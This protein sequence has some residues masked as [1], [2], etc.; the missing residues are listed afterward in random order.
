[1]ETGPVGEPPKIQS[2][3]APG[4][5]EEPSETGPRVDQEVLIRAIK[6]RRMQRSEVADTSDNAKS[7]QKPGPLGLPISPSLPPVPQEV[8]SIKVSQAWLPA[9]DKG[10][11]PKVSVFPNCQNSWQGIGEFFSLSSQND[12]FLE[13]FPREAFFIHFQES[14]ISGLLN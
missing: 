11:T 4:V 7:G 5:I 12:I 6:V 3:L 8:Q 9:A 1:M 10:D 13:T 14:I 2:F